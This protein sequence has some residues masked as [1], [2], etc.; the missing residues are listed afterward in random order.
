M[1]QP[2]AAIQITN[3][4]KSFAQREVLRGV[5]LQVPRASLFGFLGPNGAGKT[6]TIRVLLGLL[7]ASAGRALVFGDDALRRGAALRRRIGY[8]PGDVR[9]YDWLT[10]RAT[11]DFLDHARGGGG[12][13]EI[14][15]LSRC[16]DLDLSRR[17][18][19]YSRGMKQKLGL[20]Q[21]LMHRPELL[22]LDEP[23]TA[24]DPLMQRAL[25]DEL[26]TVSRDGRTVL[27]SSHTLGEVEELC[28]QVAILRAG[29]VVE[30][31]RIDV[32]RARA[33]RHVEVTFGPG[34]ELAAP[35]PAGLRALRREHNHLSAAWTGPIG[36]LLVWLAEVRPHDAEIAPPSLE[37]LFLTYYATENGDAA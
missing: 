24:L 3:L 18:R 11:L 14:T 2:S 19:S 6:T 28:D 33:V 27:F 20:I 29:R 25:Y 7:R 8:L 31:E 15:R 34:R 35:L 23:T 37:D 16:F 32:L 26:R 1:S 30:Q 13:T 12:R 4:R 36:E 22:V 10:G 5:E 21:A 9:F 17:V